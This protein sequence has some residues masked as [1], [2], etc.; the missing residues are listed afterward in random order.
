MGRT[1]GAHQRL[2]RSRAELESMTIAAIRAELVRRQTDRDNAKHDPAHFGWWLSDGKRLRPPHLQLIS[3]RIAAHVENGNGRL[4][5]AAPPRHGKS[6]LISETVP[7]WRIW[8]APDKRVIQCSYG[9]TF[10]ETWG[11]K[12]RDMLVANQRRTGLMIV[13]G[14]DSAAGDWRTEQGGGMMTAGV[15][16]GILGRGADLLIID[17]PIKNASEAYSPAYQERLRDWYQSTASTRLEPGGTVII[18]M[19]RWPEAD[20]VS[21][22]M[23]G[24][25]EGRE[26]WELL[27][28]PALAEG[29]DPVGRKPGEPLW[30][31]RYDA[32]A[33]NRIRVSMESE[34]FWLAQWQQRPPEKSREG[35]AY[36]AFSPEHSVRECLY[37]PR[38]PL[39]WALDFNVDPMC[40]VIAQVQ[41]D[42]R[43]AH[44]DVL[45]GT[46]TDE[47]HQKT[48]RVLDE[49][50][51]HNSSTQ[52]ACVE[53]IKRCEPL[54]KGFN[55]LEVIVYGDASGHSR[56]TTAPADYRVI[57]EMF[58]ADGRFIFSIRAQKNNPGQRDRV[59]TVN[60]AFLNAAGERRL[61]I[62]PHCIEL[63]KDLLHMR[64][65]R[66][67]AGNP[68]PGLDDSNPRRGHLS[69][70]LGYLVWG[71]LRIQ[72]RV[73]YMPERIF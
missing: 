60:N 46:R 27:A 9:A 20:F 13:G 10:A 26:Q 55:K 59:T 49:I 33:L 52:A 61:F 16:G 65:H 43:A 15:M 11:R 4:I 23:E 50:Y 72:G 54:L 68:T 21:W 41:E 30:H 63:R 38:L 31:E 64:W 14:Q 57:E 73:G 8:R 22:L 48:I 2:M 53:F 5:I 1:L 58:R 34:A 17:D 25:K 12:V 36:F 66:D 29:D 71:E 67:V 45:H 56:K 7:A 19:Q 39:S 3:D 6:S 51:L 18:T 47:L 37:N 44:Y 35:L 28:L 40:S 24:A 70:A 42:S 32:A 69:D 62:P